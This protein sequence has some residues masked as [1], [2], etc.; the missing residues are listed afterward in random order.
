VVGFPSLGDYTSVLDE[1][2]VRRSGVE[3]PPAPVIL[4][5]AQALTG[6]HDA[7]PVR[8]DGQLLYKSRTASEKLCS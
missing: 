7:E 5:A 3:R 8:I 2:I 6:D 4:T 1:A